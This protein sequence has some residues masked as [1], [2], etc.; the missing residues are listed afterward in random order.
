MREM[1]TPGVRR[2]GLARALLLAM[3]LMGWCGSG[4]ASAAP[5]LLLRVEGAIGPASADYVVRGLARGEKDAAQLVLLQLDTPGGLD[6]SMRQ[7]IKAILAAKVPVATFVAPSGA[8][9][10]AVARAQCAMGRA[11]GA[12]G[13]QPVGH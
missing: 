9:A 7:I 13:S 10:G 4:W 5:V 2:R 1:S 8:R 12:R 11:G 3:L 6:T